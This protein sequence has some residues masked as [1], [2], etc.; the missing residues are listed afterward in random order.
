MKVII[1]PISFMAV[2]VIFSA[3]VHADNYSILIN[4]DVNNIFEI[5]RYELFMVKG[6]PTERQEYDI[7]DA[8]QMKL[9]IFTADNSSLFY[10]GF[11]PNFFLFSDPPQE[12]NETSVL[13]IL[14]YDPRAKYVKVYHENVEKLSFNLQ[15]SL[16]NINRVCEG[17]ENYYSC[18]NDCSLY[19]ED[20]VCASVSFDG[21]CDPD[22]PANI[23]LDCSCPDSVC[24]E[25]ENY[26]LCQQD[27]RSGGADGFCDGL[28]DNKCDQ[29]CERKQDI[30][31]TCPDNICQIF[32]S[33]KTC[34]QDCKEEAGYLFG[35]EQN[36]LLVLVSIAGLVIIVIV[37]LVLVLKK[38]PKRKRRVRGVI[39]GSKEYKELERRLR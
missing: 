4:L 5:T 3:T 7:L 13:L 16:C 12:L 14:P 38:R 21:G 22:C 2:F 9:E 30:D 18:P 31:C 28:K 10:T 19:A 24:Q 1:V 15:E 17:Y 34:P 26:K 25:W 23:D 8:T 6:E 37:V 32:E 11:T 39:S 36:S 20:G 33:R 27:C 35:I 29:D